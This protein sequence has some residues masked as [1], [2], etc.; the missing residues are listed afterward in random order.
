MTTPNFSQHHFLVVDDKQFLRNLIQGILLQCHAGSIKHAVHGAA[1]VNVLGEAQSRIDCVLC[2][3]N[4]EPVNGLELLQMIRTQRIERVRQ[5]LRFIMMTGHGEASV[6]KAAIALDVSGFL[7]KPVSSDQ[8]IKA[9]GTAFAKPV[10]LKS[11]GD[12]A[13]AAEVMLPGGSQ[14]ESKWTPPW[15]L[16]SG[17][18]PAARDQMSE[19]LELIQS[20]SGKS[21]LRRKIRNAKTLP[22]EEIEAGTVLAE[23]IHNE[24]GRLLLST[25]TVLDQTLLRRLHEVMLV[26]HESIRLMVGEFEE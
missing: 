7:V 19:R 14:G 20:E 8:L 5:D 12:Y 26:S 10:K 22:L 11:P 3:W 21:A 16:L 24:A 15:V 6:V 9:I 18:R 4:M 2:D 25:G 1:A 13:A 23:D 17:M